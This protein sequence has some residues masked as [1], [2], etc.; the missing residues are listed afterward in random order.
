[1]A[2]QLT[3]RHLP[4][5]LAIALQKEKRRRGVSLNQTVKDVL[6]Q[7]LGLGSSRRYANGLGKLSGGWTQAELDSFEK[8]TAVFERIDDDAWK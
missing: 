1:M 3:V 8:A 6:R 7:G 5:D 2:R 4:K